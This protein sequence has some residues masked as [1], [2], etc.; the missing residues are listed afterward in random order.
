MLVKLTCV[1]RTK[2]G[3]YLSK[4]SVS[5]TFMLNLIHYTSSG[6]AYMTSRLSFV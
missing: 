2:M 5:I 4:N 6:S 3:V 1:V